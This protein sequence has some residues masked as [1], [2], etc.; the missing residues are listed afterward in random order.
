VVATGIDNLDSAVLAQP[1]ESS[2]TELASRLRDD[3][4]QIADRVPPTDSSHRR[5]GSVRAIKEQSRKTVTW[6]PLQTALHRIRRL[7]VGVITSRLVF[8]VRHLGLNSNC[9]SE[10]AVGR[11]AR[12]ATSFRYW[13][14]TGLETIA[15]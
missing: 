2:L 7:N 8:A 6:G 12:L 5:V 4:P 11:C 9:R 13:A 1:V 3:S 10:G 15:A 14:K